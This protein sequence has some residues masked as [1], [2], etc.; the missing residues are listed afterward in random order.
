MRRADDMVILMQRRQFRSFCFFYV[1]G[2]GPFSEFYFQF[3][4]SVP[5]S[6]SP[7]SSRVLALKLF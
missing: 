5:I 4:G 6:L 1:V 2:I 7:C 3:P